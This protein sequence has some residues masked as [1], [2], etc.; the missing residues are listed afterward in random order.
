MVIITRQNVCR[1]ATFLQISTIVKR[2]KFGIEIKMQI[3]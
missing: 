2:W 3:A 1:D